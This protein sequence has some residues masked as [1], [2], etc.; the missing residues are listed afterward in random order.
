MP[1]KNGMYKIPVPGDIKSHKNLDEK[2]YKFFSIFC[3]I[4]FRVVKFQ[5]LTIIF[6]TKY[7]IHMI[8]L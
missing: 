5:I 3:L 4:S 8:F 7:L 1:D 6:R 2:I